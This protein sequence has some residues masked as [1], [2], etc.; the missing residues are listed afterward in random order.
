MYKLFLG[1]VT[2]VILAYGGNAFAQS[3]QGGYL[4][5]NPG[6]HQ[7]AATPEQTRAAEDALKSSPDTWCWT[8]AWVKPRPSTLIVCSMIRTTT[9]PAAA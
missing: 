8:A 6:G 4:G 3:G 5:L 2:A 7:T 1:V 9:C